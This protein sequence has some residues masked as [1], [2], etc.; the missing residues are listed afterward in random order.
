MLRHPQPPLT[1]GSTA[2]SSPSRIAAST[3]VDTATLAELLKRLDRRGHVRREPDPKDARR[4]L[5]RLGELPKD[6][7][8]NGLQAAAEVNA[9]A[10]HGF[11]ASERADAHALLARIRANLTP[12]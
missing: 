9:L 1:G 6:L 7:L 2:T 4:L 11:T 8:A 5:V 3:G 12:A 10:T